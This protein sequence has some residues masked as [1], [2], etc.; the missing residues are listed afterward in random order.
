MAERELIFADRPPLAFDVLSIGIG[1]VPSWQG[2]E[3]VDQSRVVPIK[4]MQTF[5]ARLNEQLCAA[6]VARVTAPLRIVTV[7]GGAGGVE[8]TL[9]LPAY[10]RAR[11][12]AH[13][14][15]EQTIVCGSADVLPAA[16]GEP[17]AAWRGCVSVAVF[18]SSAAER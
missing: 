4:P 5:L 15:V 7:G 13:A 14:R 9:C 2:V 3:C 10:V 8:V 16:H 6:S 12:G 1:S 18:R 11:L 17:W